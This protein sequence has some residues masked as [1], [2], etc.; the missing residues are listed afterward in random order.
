MGDIGRGGDE[1]PPIFCCEELSIF[2]ESQKVVVEDVVI[3]ADREVNE[4]QAGNQGISME[5]EIIDENEAISMNENP[6]NDSVSKNTTSDNVDVNK[7]VSNNSIEHVKL[8]LWV[9]LCNIPLEACSVKGINALASRVGKPLI[10]DTITIQMCYLGTRRL[11]YARVLVE[12][13]AKEDLVKQIEI[14]YRS[15]LDDKV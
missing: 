7:N 9:K 13:E 15:K 5:E 3:D 6:M 11:G 10:M 14:Q 2:V 12:V 1:K 8:P 4:E